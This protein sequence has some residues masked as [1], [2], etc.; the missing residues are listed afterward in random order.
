MLYKIFNEG[1]TI[2]IKIIIGI[3]VQIISINW[4]CKILR[5]I[6]WFL[7]NHII[8]YKIIIKIINK[9]III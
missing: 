3:I 7:K 5:L 6:N 9:I 8:R 4:L 1:I 2:N